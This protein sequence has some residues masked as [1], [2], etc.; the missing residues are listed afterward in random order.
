[1]GNL[2]KSS[3]PCEACGSS[4]AK[5]IYETN[6]YCF[7]CGAYKNKGQSMVPLTS[8][9]R[10]FSG[11]VP[12]DFTTALPPTYVVWFKACGVPLRHVKEQGIGYSSKNNGLIIP[13]TKNQRL[14][15]YQIRRIEG[16]AKALNVGHTCPIFMGTE[17]KAC[18]VE[19]IRSA[20]KIYRHVSTICLMGTSCSK[21]D[22]VDIANKYD[23]IWL[24]LDGDR[25]GQEAAKKIFDK[26]KLCTIVNNIRTIKDPKWYSHEAIIKLLGV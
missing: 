8:A 13:F 26:L 10:S 14:I 2:I 19:D 20:L 3:L 4:D 18:I 21:E 16:D 17:R 23:K 12:E 7:S 6:T 5:A 25:P 11:A 24:W 15:G 22:I 1:M 9:P